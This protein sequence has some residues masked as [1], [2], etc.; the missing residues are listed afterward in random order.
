MR[1][2][3]LGITVILMTFLANLYLVSSDG[4]F[5]RLMMLND[6]ESIAEDN[7]YDI[8]LGKELRSFY[9]E[10]GSEYYEC[11]YADADDKCHY[12]LETFCGAGD[13]PAE[14]GTENPGEVND[15]CAYDGH[16]F[17]E[18]RC[19]RTCVRCN[20]SSFICGD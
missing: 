3:I 6:V 9:C 10:S 5:E 2:K 19:Y 4:T 1:K 7:E 17:I 18:T 8:V 13:S 15:L 20:L 14:G 11:M 12:S 16:I